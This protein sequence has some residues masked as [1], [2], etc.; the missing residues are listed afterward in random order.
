[1]G[2]ITSGVGLI[3]GINTSQIIDQLISLDAAPQTQLQGRISANTSIKTAYTTLEASLTSLLSNANTLVRPSTFA[4]AKAASSNESVLTATTSTG[5]AAGTYQF[6]V[7]R[8]VSSESQISSGYAS[9]TTPIG[10]GTI[11]IGLGGGEVTS[12]ENLSDLNGGNGVRRGTFRVTDKSGATV[13]IDLS[14]AVSLDD[15][16][17]KINTAD[18]ISVTASIGENGLVLTD[19]SGGSGTLKVADTAG[20]YAAQDLGIAGSATGT[21]LTGSDINTI[22]RNTPLST[23]NDG[24]GVGTTPG[25]DFTINTADGSAVGVSL[26]GKRTVGEVLDAINSAS[27]GKVTASL[28]SDGR[29]IQ[30]TDK[31]TGA[32][33]LAVASATGSQA[34][35]DLGLTGTSSGGTLTG[36]TLKA[37]LGSVLTRTL[38]GGAGIGT[39]T[40]DITDHAG[41]TAHITVDASTSSL[42]DLIKNINN[43]G[44]GITASINKAGTGITLTDSSTGS[45]AITVADTSGTVAAKLNIAGTAATGATT[46]ESGSLQRQYITQNSTLS[47]LN[48]GKGISLGKF[49]ITSASGA[50]SEIDL[51]SLTDGTLGDVI[52]I[53][54]AKN[55]G[56]TASI[57]AAGNG[58]QLTDTSGG[59]G[60]LTVA[61]TSGTAAADLRVSGTATTNVL[62]GANDATITLDAT[63]TLTSLVTKVN[64]AKI[65]VSAS[66]LNDGSS[67]NPYRLSLAS[68]GTGLNG[69]FSF[70]TGSTGI[71]LTNLTTAQNAAVFLGSSTGSS[72]VL[73][74]SS[75]NT[76]T[77][78]V[79][80]VTLNINS[81]SSSPVSLTITQNADTA[82][83]TINSFVTTFNALTSKINTYTTYN[84]TTQQKGLLLGDS[85]AT[86]ITDALFSAVQNSVKGA[87][88]YSS[89]SQ[90]GLTVGADNQLSF[91]SDKFQTAY[92]ADPTSVARL[93]TAFNQLTTTTTTSPAGASL[94]TN[95]TTLP[96][97]TATAGTS[98]T[99]D[100]NGNTV[101][102]SIT[103]SGFGFGYLIQNA[104]NRLTD[105]TNGTIT[106]TTKALDDENTNFQ[107]RIESLQELLDAK[108]SR[109]QEQFANMETTLSTLQSQQSSI[110]QIKSVS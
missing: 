60:K 92:N 94:S 99:T 29:G 104:I 103:T 67:S 1:M 64:N 24:N 14:S 106:L 61:D 54:N 59:T 27:G 98:T 3:S 90:I 7:A 81:A 108:K 9:T 57:N 49:T 79:N 75:S 102:T 11:H 16:V 20:G 6:T 87:G 23:L 82:V 17:S 65:G 22:G 32:G 25:T 18:N 74:N 63:D 31:T 47:S 73:I 72:P 36:D 62:D 85:T 42:D 50:S 76:L 88:R 55:I 58:L 109:L 30:L 26:L 19:T 91:D 52:S 70:D 110:S 77:N 86:G 53:I 78:V 80:G 5:A 38:S 40:F 41:N 101:T 71:S 8:T 28:R 51:T 12:S 95:T 66:I 39:G 100:S 56:V 89:L 48:G 93:F 21:T 68:S 37:D 34:A 33:T 44:T 69:R 43:A 83:S 2:T 84:S 35:R 107:D 96:F 15:V 97:G 4:T 105:P 45:G 46:V 10:A 13:T